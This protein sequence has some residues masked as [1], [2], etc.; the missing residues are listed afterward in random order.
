M[1]ADRSSVMTSLIRWCVLALLSQPALISAFPA[2]AQSEPSGPHPRLFLDEQTQ[3]NL[4]DLA[5]KSGTAVS[6]AVR[7]CREIE[8]SPGSFARDGYMGLDWAQY[9]QTCLVAW[10]AT[11]SEGA[12]RT[13]IRY[14]R[15]LLNDLQVV[16]D[17]KGGDSAASRDSGYAMRAHGPYT[18][19]AY[20][21]LHDAPGVDAALLALARSRFKAW[22]GWYVANG[23]RA[24]SP[25]T[26][27]NAGYFFAATLIAVA[28]GGEA[29][30]DG[31]KL[32]RHVVDSLFEKDLLPAMT[33]GALR[34]GDGGEVWQYTPPR[35]A[36]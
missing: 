32:W 30:D 25:G 19:L 14:F 5:R 15:A 10:K 1:S 23:Y 9:L 2:A 17:G 28:Q 22:T 16:G 36:G 21:W 33:D 11:G 18:A 34:G 26:N 20:D 29:G 3:A 6:A 4:R 7:R 27:Y 12:A 31:A 13:A 35:V 8:S 24:R